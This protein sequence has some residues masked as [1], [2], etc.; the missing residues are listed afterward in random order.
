[1]TKKSVWSDVP[2]RLVT[3]CVGVP[4]VWKLLE[5]PTTAYIFFFGAHAISAW[6]YSLLEPSITTT[7]TSSASASDETACKQFQ[8]RPQQ[9]SKQTRILFCI[10]SIALASIPDS[11]SSFFSFAT[12]LA[13][14]IFAVTNRFHWIIGLLVVT[15]PF[16]AWCNLVYRFESNGNDTNSSAFASTIAVLLTVWN[17]DTGALVAGR[18]FGRKNA[19]V[20]T[21]GQVSD[22]NRLPYWIQRISPSKTMEGFFGGIVG[23]IVTAVWAVPLL[24]NRF[25]ID[26]SP[27]YRKLWGLDAI[28]NGEGDFT[29]SAAAFGIAN[30]FLLGFCLSVLAILGDLVESSIKRRSR[31]KDSGSVLPGHGGILDRFDSSLLAVLFYRAILEHVNNLVS[32]TDGVY[33]QAQSTIEEGNVEL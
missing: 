5:R 8:S 20:T 2:R 12:A 19:T 29:T 18:L 15:I 23:G 6:E 30:R 16:R 21:G 24:L 26:T 33:S 32:E 7:T 17:A 13:A 11:L 4:F 31:S 28:K 22:T 3:I 14:G 27:G 10:V 25:S 9:L 1:M